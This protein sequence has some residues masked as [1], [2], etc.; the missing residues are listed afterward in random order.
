MKRLGVHFG[1]NKV[2]AGSYGGWPGYLAG[3]WNDAAGMA[4]TL[5]SSGYETRGWFDAD[6]TLGRVRQELADAAT[7]LQSGDTFVFSDS[8]HGGQTLGAFF[9]STE[10]LCFYD[11]QLADTELRAMLSQFKPGVNV[12]VI[13]DSCHSGGMDRAA[14]L[15]PRVAPLWV[16]KDLPVTPALRTSD[17]IL[18]NVLLIAACQRDEVAG[19]GD[20]NGAFTG[21]LLES[22][23]TAPGSKVQTWQQWFDETSRYMS[24]NFP[25]Q[26]PVLTSLNGNLASLPVS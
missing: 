19:D 14:G 10:T 12:V 18:A 6:C 21:S 25:Q 26:H 13:L 16:T 1:M 17:R 2:D 5:A 9:G 11:G 7:G 22:L 24:R 23:D 8:G 20:A 15:R 4:A 3:C